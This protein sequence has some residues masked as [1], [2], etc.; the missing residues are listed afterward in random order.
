MGVTPLYACLPCLPWTIIGVNLEELEKEITCAICH[1]H[2]TD[3]KLLPC[4]HY[5]CK[6]CIHT[7]ALRTGIGKPFP[8]PECRTDTTLPQGGVDHLKPAF[9]INRM[10]AIH[11]NLSK[12]HGKVEAM[13]ESCSGDKAE[14]FCRQCTEFICAECIRLH[15]RLKVFSGHKTVSLNELKKGGAKDIVVPK[16]PLKM[17]E[18]HDEQMKI[19]C[20]DC[21]CLIC[22]DCIIENHNGHKH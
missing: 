14:A 16:A 1:E 5:Y 18:E 2:Y 11:T 20:F 12:A 9:V 7:L 17:C 6:Q 3:P 21:N 15:Q 19:Y 22:R 10:T 13:C 4:L 8:C